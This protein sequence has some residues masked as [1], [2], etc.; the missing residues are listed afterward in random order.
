M[1]GLFQRAG[2]NRKVRGFSNCDVWEVTSL[3]SMQGHNV[4]KNGDWCP[5]MYVTASFIVSVMKIKCLWGLK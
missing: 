3:L 1:N 5:A 2:A 4:K